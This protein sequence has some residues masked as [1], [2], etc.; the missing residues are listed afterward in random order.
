MNILVTGST[1]FIGYHLVNQLSKLNYKIYGCDSLSSVSKKTQRLRLKNQKLLKNFYFKKTN[2]NNFDKLFSEY[3]NKKIDIVIHLA[4]QPGV[5]LSQKKPTE[6]IDNNI[7][8]F[9]NILEFCVK[10]KIKN[11]FFASSSSVYG[12]NPNQSE[13]KV[14]LNTNS[15]YAA[16]KLSNEI[17]ANTYNYLYGLNTLGL[18]F[19]TVYGEYGRED[20]VYFKFMN[21]VREKNKITIFGDKNSQRSF[22]YIDDVI[23]AIIILIKKFQNK[24]NYNEILNIGNSKNYK[25][26]ELIEIIQNS[27]KFKEIYF[28][29]N[30]SD[31]LKQNLTQ[32]N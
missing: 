28:P 4:A 26:E 17:L 27:K 22:T 1:G 5:R 11:F 2:L 24:K 31:V 6:T 23:K 10:K 12:E 13:N 32:Q 18:R 7:K 25:L 30:K 20:M 19:F 9:V 21:Q 16:S 15:I 3:K 8:S 29:R 14:N